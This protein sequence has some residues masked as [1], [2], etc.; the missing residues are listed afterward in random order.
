MITKDKNRNKA[1]LY[2]ENYYPYFSTDQLQNSCAC[3]IG[4]INAIINKGGFTIVL[5]TWY[6][7]CNLSEFSPFNSLTSHMQD[8]YRVEYT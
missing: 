2:Q 7:T 8:C 1:C 6:N 3:G 4:G 5:K